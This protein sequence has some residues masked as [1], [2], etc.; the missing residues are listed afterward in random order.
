MLLGLV[1]ELARNTTTLS[2]TTRVRCKNKED[3]FEEN[4]YFSLPYVDHQNVN[5]LGEMLVNPFPYMTIPQQTTL[6][7]DIKR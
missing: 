1:K 6:K 2:R 4:D 3:I 7:K 5:T